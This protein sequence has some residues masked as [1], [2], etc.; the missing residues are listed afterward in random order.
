MSEPAADAK[1]GQPARFLLLDGEAEYRSR[2]ASDLQ[3]RGTVAPDEAGTL[4][5]ARTILEEGPGAPKVLVA[6]IPAENALQFFAYLKDWKAKT[7]EAALVLCSYEDMSAWYTHAPEDT[8]WFFKPL[9][10]EALFDWLAQVAPSLAAAPPSPL[11][12]PE[13]SPPV[14]I[15]VPLETAKPAPALPPRPPLDTVLGDYK[16]TGIIQEE[17]DTTTYEATQTS[18]GRR[19]ALRFLHRDQLENESRV[20]GFID[21]AR[22]QALIS[23]PDIAVVYEAGR[24]D[25]GVYYAL[26]NID[27]HPLD[28]LPAGLSVSETDFIYFLERLVAAVTYLFASPN[29]FRPLTASDLFYTSDHA[30]RVANTVGTP[31]SLAAADEAEQVRLLGAALEP[32]AAKVRGPRAPAC[33]SLVERMAN[34]SRGD[35]ITNLNELRD[36]VD[37]FQVMLS[38]EPLSQAEKIQRTNRN[39]VIVGVSIGGIILLLGVAALLMVSGKPEAKSFDHMVPVPAGEFIYQDGERIRLESF[40]IDEYEV[41]IAQYAEFLEALRA[42]PGLAESLR[43]ERQPAAKTSYEPKD[44]EDLHAAAQSGRSFKGVPV[45]LNC[46]VFL[47]DWWDAHAY[48]QWKGR[49]LPTEEEWEKA[50][51]GRSGNKYPW[52]TEMDPKRFNSGADYAQNGSDSQL[53]ADGFP[54]WSPVDAVPGDE[55]PYFVKGMAGN[56]TEW[57]SSWTYHPDFPDRSVP[58]RRGASFATRADFELSTRRPAESADEALVSVGFRTVSSTPPAGDGG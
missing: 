14:R 7:P 19:V 36:S 38:G 48:A 53:T 25:Q 35:A 6:A 18:I 54:Y 29:P 10:E 2:L 1:S 57:T 26:E 4:A 33:Q 56:V 43:D 37:G 42:D 15:A 49:R 23:Q 22:A 9:D 5:E 58:V 31:D 40:W 32:L 8:R 21:D 55:S 11:A 24:H 34:P 50:A 39:A 41:T 12:T 46:P 3:S 20:R 17:P 28:R 30:V 45:D 27:G 52:G 44:W 47:V 51:R 16:L 13:A